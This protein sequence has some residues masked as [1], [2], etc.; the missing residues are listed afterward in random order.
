MSQVVLGMPCH[1]M[2]ARQSAQTVGPCVARPDGPLKEQKFAAETTVR[3]IWLLANRTPTLNDIEKAPTAGGL[4]SLALP[5]EKF[6][7][8]E[9]ESCAM[10]SQPEERELQIR[11][12]FIHFESM[13]ASEQRARR[14][15]SSPGICHGKIED[16][17]RIADTRGDISLESGAPDASEATAP[18]TQDDQSEVVPANKLGMSRDFRGGTSLSRIDLMR[19][20]GQ[21]VL[22]SLRASRIQ[23]SPD[24]WNCDDPGMWAPTICSEVVPTGHAVDPTAHFVQVQ[25]GFAQHFSA[26]P[27]WPEL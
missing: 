23:N 22:A 18:H 2:C 7:N 8:P 17:M 19:L 5:R 21:A 24:V 10:E 16:A 20:K 26:G 12:T 3:V 13:D 15:K 25:A 6:C 14:W 11:C 1:G 4:V 9:C 27:W